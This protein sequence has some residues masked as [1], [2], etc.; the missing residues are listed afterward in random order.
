MI[1]VSP[2]ML[3]QLLIAVGKGLVMPLPIIRALA[4]RSQDDLDKNHPSHAPCGGKTTTIER[5]QRTKKTSRSHAVAFE[6]RTGSTLHEYSLRL[7]CTFE[8]ISHQDLQAL[9]PPPRPL[10]CLHPSP[11]RTQ[12]PEPES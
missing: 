10:H 11:L 8:G 4:R 3:S 6:I 2:L 12:V 5:T 7:L 9:P 1:R